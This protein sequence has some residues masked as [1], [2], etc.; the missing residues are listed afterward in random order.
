M[1][2]IVLAT[3]NERGI[4]AE[5]IRTILK[6]VP[7]PVEVIV[8][9]D[10]S[11]DRTWEVVESLELP[12]VKVIRRRGARGLAS[13]FNRG[14]IESRGD[15]IG[16]MDADLGMPPAMIPRMYRLIVDDGYD[17]A[18]GSRYVDGGADE[19][20]PFR[21]LASHL[22]NG[23]ARLVL[24]HGVKDYDSGFVLMK[25]SVLDTVTFMP[26]GYGD[27]CIEFIYDACRKGVRIAEVGY[28]FRERTIG[29]SK[30]VPSIP[31]FLLTGMKY[32]LRI[33]RTRLKTD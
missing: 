14:I 33:V 8:V 25:R 19:R 22:I 12:N 24:G 4:I 20:R 15:Y 18:I 3:Y 16:W 29:T 10:D 13:A 31:R 32:A 17:M 27:Y 26:S 28:V 1:I 7:E 21:V 11:P 30:S 2:S 23:L 6:E 5:T 9:D